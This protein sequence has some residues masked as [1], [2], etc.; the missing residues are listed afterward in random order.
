MPDRMLT[1]PAA[2][3]TVRRRSRVHMRGARGLARLGARLG[4]GM[5]GAVSMMAPYGVLRRTTNAGRVF[6]VLF[7]V[8]AVIVGAGP[9]QARTLRLLVLGDSLAAGYGL[10][11]PEGFQ[12]QM[13]AA[14]RGAGQDV[15]LVDGAVSGDT[16]AGGRARLEW[17]I[18][19]GVD[20]VLVELGGN[21]GLRGIDP[22][23]TE[24]NLGAVLDALAGRKIPVLLSG[25]EAPPN[26]GA[27]YGDAFRAVFG[28]L[29]GRPGVLFDRFFLEGVAGDPGLNQGDRIHPNAAGVRKEVAR[30]LPRVLELLGRVGS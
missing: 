13:Q 12:A 14:L 6:A 8:W 16:S 25:M 9:L 15:T 4:G 27:E 28:R 19:D 1:G 17:A 23:N 5:A 18:G 2:E 3:G 24:A 20:A 7:L 30:L 22:A 10:S 11:Q 29:G 26:L 21:D